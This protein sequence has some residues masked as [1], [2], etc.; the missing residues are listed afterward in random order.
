MKDAAEVGSR[1]ARDRL[2]SLRELSEEWCASRQ[3]VKRS[4][5]RAGIRPVYLCDA[6][7]GTLRYSRA[8]VDCYL[9][10]CRTTA[11]RSRTVSEHVYPN[12]DRRV[13]E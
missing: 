11:G 5:D 1:T 3:T 8:E 4:L 2:V 10:S 6:R 7:N 9:E 13:P 12:T